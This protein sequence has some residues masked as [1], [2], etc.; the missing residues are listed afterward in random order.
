VNVHAMF[1]LTKAAIPLMEEGSSILFIAE[2]GAGSCL[3]SSA[4]S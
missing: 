2:L 4:P 3:S 1:Y